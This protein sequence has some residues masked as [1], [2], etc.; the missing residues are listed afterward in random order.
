MKKCSEKKLCEIDTNKKVI[1]KK[2]G[3]KV[4]GKQT[5]MQYAMQVI[6]NVM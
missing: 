3:K 4:F 2:C 1:E 5:S 6:K